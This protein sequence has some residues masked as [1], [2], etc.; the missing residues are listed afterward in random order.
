[1]NVHIWGPQNIRLKIYQQRSSDMDSPLPPALKIREY[2]QSLFKP[3]PL[4]S[5]NLNKKAGGLVEPVR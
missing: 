4:E 1:M 2:P 5:L 3:L